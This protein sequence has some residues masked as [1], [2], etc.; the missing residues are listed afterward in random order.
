MPDSISIALD[1]F[2]SK[3][4][5]PLYNK[6]IKVLRDSK[7]TG[8][9]RDDDDGRRRRT[10]TTD[11]HGRRRRRRTTDDD[12]GRTTDDD[13]GDDGGVAGIMGSRGWGGDRG[14]GID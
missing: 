12:D 9:L 5:P 8:R 7:V 1:A 13:D 3:N 14:G 2:K 11:G 6:Y 4:D 10:T